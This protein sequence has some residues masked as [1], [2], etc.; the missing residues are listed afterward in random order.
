MDVRYDGEESETPDLELINMDTDRGE[1]Q[2]GRLCTLREWHQADP[3][4]DAERNRNQ[5]IYSWQGNRNP[6]ID[7]P[8]FAA[9]IFGSECGGVASNRKQEMLELIRKIESDLN[10]LKTMVEN[11]P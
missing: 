7:H 9:S 11:E 1:P 2:F 3:V 10:A 4:D 5:I 6:F 8:E